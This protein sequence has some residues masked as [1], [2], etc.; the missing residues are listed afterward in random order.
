MRVKTP[1]MLLLTEQAAVDYSDTAFM[2]TPAYDAVWRRL[3]SFAAMA[4]QDGTDKAYAGGGVNGLV[5]VG[6]A[7]T[8]KSHLAQIWQNRT[9]AQILHPHE[10]TLENLAQ[11]VAHHPYFLLDPMESMTPQAEKNFFHFFGLLAELGRKNQ[12]HGLLI[13]AQTPPLTWNIALPDL[14]SR[15]RALPLENLPALGGGDLAVLLAKFFYE[16]QIRVAPDVISYILSHAER[17]PDFLRRFVAELDQTALAAKKPITVP[18]VRDLLHTKA[19]PDLPFLA[20][21][22]FA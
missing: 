14:A 18:M 8:G 6:A 22:G 13:T 21:E 10:L 20:D 2:V 1:Q 17:S 11:L 9:K 5:L 19:T 3:D 4:Q 15:L 16:R 7:G 12:A